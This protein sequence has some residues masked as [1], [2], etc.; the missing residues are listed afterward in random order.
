MQMTALEWCNFLGGKL[1]GNG[2]AV[3]T[4]PAKI[5]EADE[6]S[7]SFIAHPKYFSHVY[8]TKASALIVSNNA[9][10]ENEVTAT[11]IRVDQPYVAFSR[12]L[13]KFN[14]PYEGLTGI[15]ETSVFDATVTF[16]ENVFVGA[17]SYLGKNVTLGKNVK[18]FPEVFVGDGVTIEDDTI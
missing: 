4:H 3:V 9:E 5:E 15:H 7:I 18:I 13:E 12:V 14:K 2:D 10:L 8:S 11:L 17:M 1:E 6:G 16:G